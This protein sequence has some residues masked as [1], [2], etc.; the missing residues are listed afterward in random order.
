VAG[1]WNHLEEAD[2]PALLTIKSTLARGRNSFVRPLAVAL[3]RFNQAY[4]RETAEDR[5]IDL[6]VCLE[7]CLLSGVED[8]LK[9]RLSL[10]A[11][12]LLADRNDPERTQVMLN[13]VYQARSSI[14]HSGKQLSDVAAMMKSLGG[15]TPAVQPHE[16]PQHCEDLVRKELMAYLTHLSAGRSVADIKF[17]WRQR[18]HQAHETS[19]LACQSPPR[20]QF[21]SNK[22]LDR[23]IVRSL[24]AEFPSERQ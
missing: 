12:A 13:A 4:A 2:V 16:L 8:E 19:S 23:K 7:S 22:D 6:T 18:H 10:R 15:L 3:R 20:R 14:V 11:A 17:S 24:R 9:Y 5:L 1:L 21:H